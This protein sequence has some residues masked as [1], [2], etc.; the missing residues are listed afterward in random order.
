MNNKADWKR[1]KQM[2]LQTMTQKEEKERK[3]RDK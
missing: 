2:D 3:K 1:D